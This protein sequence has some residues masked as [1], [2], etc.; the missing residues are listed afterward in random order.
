MPVAMLACAAALVGG[1]ATRPD[2]AAVVRAL[3]PFAASSPSLQGR[4]ER[5]RIGTTRLE[6]ASAALGA[7]AAQA[8]TD[9][10]L[11]LLWWQHFEGGLAPV[12][13]LPIANAFGGAGES[14]L[15]RSQLVFGPD[16]LLREVRQARSR[17]D[18][19]LQDPPLAIS[20]AMPWSVP[21]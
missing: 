11:R 1:C 10:G 21:R 2:P 13:L 20:P 17:I 16:L 5:M 14:V 15:V 3:S 4:I 18:G 12:S 19:R 8:T 6:E 7:P 9:E